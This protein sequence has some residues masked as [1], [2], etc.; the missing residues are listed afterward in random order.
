M[1]GLIQ[2][3]KLN[4]QDYQTSG[5]ANAFVGVKGKAKGTTDSQRGLYIL[6]AMQRIS[7]AGRDK[8]VQVVNQISHSVHIPNYPPHQISHRSKNVRASAEAKWEGQVHKELATPLHSQ[9]T[10][11]IWANCNVTICGLHIKLSL[12]GPRPVFFTHVDYLVQVNVVHG[13]LIRIN[14]IINARPM[15]RRQVHNKAPLA[16]LTFF[17]DYPETARL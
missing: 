3:V 2:G 12:Q 8:N 13:K 9:K 11:T 1:G 5:W 10:T 7:R 14:T 17:E 16:G 4:S 15:G 6:R